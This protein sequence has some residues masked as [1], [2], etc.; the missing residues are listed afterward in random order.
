[1]LLQIT[2]TCGMNCP[3]CMQNSTID[4]QHMD[5]QTVDAFLKMLDNVHVLTVAITGGEPMMHPK[6]FE[7][8]NKVSLKVPIVTILTNG[9]W[10]GDPETVDNVISLL[11]TY[12]KLMIQVTSVAKYYKDHS[13]TLRLVDAFKQRLKAEGLKR[14]MGLHSEDI[15]LLSLGRCTQH[16][17]MMEEA[18]HDPAGT[19]SCLKGATFA[20]QCTS[21]QHALSVLEIKGA[22][23]KPSIDWK[24]NIRWSE[25]W[26]CPSFSSVFDDPSE[27]GKRAMGW[28]PCGK[29]ADYQKLLNRQDGQYPV[30]RKLLGIEK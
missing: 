22:F 10:M 16:P 25:C 20:A 1:M 19:C 7:I 5:D 3:H 9:F 2:N 27:I 13:K 14:R 12:P 17:E 15:H 26:L 30:V 28:R 4:P 6:W 21:F 11:K 18:A 23:C 29:C 24:G 8:V